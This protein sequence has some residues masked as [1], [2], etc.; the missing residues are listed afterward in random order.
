MEKKFRKLAL[1]FGKDQVT[2]NVFFE[3]LNQ[4]PEPERKAMLLT[5]YQLALGDWEKLPKRYKLFMI[6]LIRKDRQAWVDFL[7][8]QTVIGQV[9]YTP[10]RPKLF[11][12]AMKIIE[13]SERTK[14]VACKH[15]TM[16]IL[17]SFNFPF[18]INTLSKYIQNAI[19]L[20]GDV[21]K[22]IG[23]YRFDDDYEK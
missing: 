6:K 20:V 16:S 21:L 13:L 12:V 18:T 14:R 8:G 19:P 23:K 9:R 5:A 7:V 10:H 15:L 17:T 3:H 1:L 4:L 2:V 22:L 11:I